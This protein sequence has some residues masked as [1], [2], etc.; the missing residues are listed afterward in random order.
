MSERKIVGYH[1]AEDA[2]EVIQGE[3][4][5]FIKLGFQP[6]GDL[7]IHLLSEEGNEFLYGVQVMVKYENL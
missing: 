2:L 1:I 3:I 7:K 5:K 6:S 4:I